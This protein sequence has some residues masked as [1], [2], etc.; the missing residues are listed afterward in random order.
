MIRLVCTTAGVIDVGIHYRREDAC[1]LV[2]LEAFSYD[3][4]GSLMGI[5]GYEKRSHLK[6]NQAPS[7]W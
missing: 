5:V 6:Q 1:L 2:V 3:W 7:S 4:S